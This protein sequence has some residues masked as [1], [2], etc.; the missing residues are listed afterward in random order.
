MAQF[1]GFA[2][3][4]HLI[5]MCNDLFALTQCYFPIGTKYNIKLAVRETNQG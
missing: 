4:K 2:F 1:L 5:N 3:F